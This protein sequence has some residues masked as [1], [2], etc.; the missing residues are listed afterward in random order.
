MTRSVLDNGFDVV[1][2]TAGGKRTKYSVE[3]LSTGAIKNTVIGED[4]L[5]SVSTDDL[6]GVINH[7]S[8]DGTKTT[9]AVKPDPRFG[10]EAPITDTLRIKTPAGLTSAF[11]QSKTITQYIGNKV[12]GLTDSI[13][14]Q[15]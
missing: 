12:T 10:M 3:Y 14:Y 2:S 8:P 13:N 4:N 1:A 5:T 6:G 9:S 7:I 11:T 15:R